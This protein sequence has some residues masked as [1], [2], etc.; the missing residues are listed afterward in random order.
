MLATMTP[1]V[2]TNR[3]QRLRERVLDT[4]PSICAER[5]LLVTEAYE[6]YAADPPVLRR[7]KALSHVLDHM[8]IRIDEGEL[9]VGNQASA[10]R[11][12]PLFPEY[13]ADF[14]VKEVDEFAHRRADV[15][16]VS[17]D[18]KRAILE[19]IGPWWHGQTLYDHAQAMRPAE[20]TQ[21]EKIGAISGR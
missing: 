19:E 2:C 16:T 3:V 13:E 8:T 10:P 7:A 5:G 11:A 15:Y 1:N 14:L 17:A 12:A 20:V 21:A 6:M 18:V 4:T 9:I